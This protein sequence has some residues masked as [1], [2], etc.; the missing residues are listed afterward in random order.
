MPR[1]LECSYHLISDFL[2]DALLGLLTGLVFPAVARLLVNCTDQTHKASA[3]HRENACRYCK[4]KSS[5]TPTILQRIASID[6][7]ID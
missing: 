2:L 7:G 3:D 1:G 5:P 4:A 6:N